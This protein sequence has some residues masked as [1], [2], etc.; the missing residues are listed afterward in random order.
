MFSQLRS[1][2][3]KGDPMGLR[4]PQVAVVLAVV[5]AAIVAVGRFELLCLDE[6]GRVPDT[7]SRHLS[8]RAWALV[9]AV[10][11]PLGGI[12]FLYYGRPR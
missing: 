7:E 11:I 1:R 6:L 10:L 5:L 8:R 4:T 2:G 12:A 9:I 3:A